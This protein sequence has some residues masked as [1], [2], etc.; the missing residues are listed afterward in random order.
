VLL[1]LIAATK[2]EILDTV[3]TTF[4]PS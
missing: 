3:R 1:Q 2:F 4:T